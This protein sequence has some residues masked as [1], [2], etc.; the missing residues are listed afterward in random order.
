MRQAIDTVPRNGDFVI[1]EDDAS[2]TYAV[3]RWSVEAAQWLDEEGKPSRLNATH[4]QPFDSAQ[5]PVVPT[6]ELGSLTDSPKSSA[7]PAR[8]EASHSA[9][10]GMTAQPQ[11][12]AKPGRSVSFWA[13]LVGFAWRGCAKILSAFAIAGGWIVQ[14]RR[15]I[16][17]IAACLVIGVVFAPFFYRSDFGQWFLQRTGSERDSG[18]KQAL[19]QEQERAG[20]LAS[21]AAAARREA[22]SQAALIR[23]AGE[24]ADREKEASARALADLRQALQFERDGAAKATRAEGERERLIGELGQALKHQED[25]TAQ[26]KQASARAA[27]ALRQEQGKVEKLGVELAT[28]RHEG[29]SQAAILRSANDEAAR[30]KEASARVT[31]ELR[32]ALQQAQDKAE[33]LASE[34][35]ATRREVEAQ[36]M[37]A[38]TASDEARRAA[39]TSKRSAEEQ[40]Q[41]L[42][43]AQAK[44]EKLGAELAAARREVQ[45]QIAVASSAWDQA[46]GVKE[47]AERSADEQQ[48]ALQQERDKTG[49]LTAEL[50]EARWNLEAQ[51]KAK[52]AEEAARDNQ[53]AAMRGELQKAKAEATLARESLEAERS[54]SQSATALSVADQPSIAPPSAPQAPTK[55]PTSDARQPTNAAPQ[56]TAAPEPGNPQAVRLIAR[57]NLLL[58]QGNIGAARNMLDRAAE[59]GSTEALFWL[60]E[61]YDPRLLSARQTYGTQSDVAK[62]R[63]LYGKALA[64]GVGEAKAR[65]EALQQ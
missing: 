43:E 37:T 54:R 41:A 40:I 3:A 22:E 31:D 19:R 45:A 6:D 14:R 15:R 42:R 29:E 61:T 64:G 56:P 10:G 32:Q 20:K 16:A 13:G 23:Q 34:L 48:R 57:A 17:T 59:M 35:A 55:A 36:T 1:L 60:A 49:K 28:A 38:R 7:S 26:A 62:A 52:A 11:R 65:L 44:A 4:W 33:K 50:A 63:D 18:L 58:E 9:S 51:A 24:A 25:E 12:T 8:G 27:E 30:M 46:A 53:L 39:A 2:G 21:D 47:A 5:S